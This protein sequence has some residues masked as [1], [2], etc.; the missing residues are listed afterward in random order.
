MIFRQGIFPFALKISKV[1]PK[2][3]QGLTLQAANY[4]PISLIPSFSKVILK[5]CAN[6]TLT[7]PFN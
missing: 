5:T 2:Y 7:I 3:K 6:Q 4:R 1:Y